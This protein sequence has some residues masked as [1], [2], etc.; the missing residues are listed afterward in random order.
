MPTT[1]IATV[2]T[3]LLAAIPVLTTIQENLIVNESTV[4]ETK[5]DRE[6]MAMLQR[7]ID[8]TKESGATTIAETVIGMLHRE[9]VVTVSQAL[10]CPLPLLLLLVVLVLWLL[11]LT[12]QRPL[13]KVE[14][15]STKKETE[16]EKE[17]G[18]GIENASSANAINSTSESSANARE[19]C[20]TESTTDASMRGNVTE[21]WTE[22][23]RKN[24]R[25]LTIARHEL[26]KGPRTGIGI[27]PGILRRLKAVKTGTEA[28]DDTVRLE[29][30]DLLRKRKMLDMELMTDNAL[31]SLIACTR[32]TTFSVFLNANA[33]LLPI[34]QR[35]TLTKIIVAVLSKH[36]E[37]CRARMITQTQTEKDA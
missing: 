4:Q 28:Q 29:L 24:E 13:P 10:Y 26:V 35:L 17:I 36:K 2:T 37:T 25:G 33:L 21:T 18:R 14:T 8:I 22:T 1:R 5:I 15:A 32:P 9:V 11:L 6:M 27:N 30:M 12:G 20:E 31:P 23:A 34:Q 3:P 16:I 19:N 7:E